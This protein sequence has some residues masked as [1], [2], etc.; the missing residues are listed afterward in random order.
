M[1]EEAV[2][3]PRVGSAPVRSSMQ[4]R[5]IKFPAERS[6][7]KLYLRD[8][9]I[10]THWCEYAEACGGVSVPSG[11]D[12]S[13][14]VSDSA[15]A[16]LAPLSALGPDDLQVI[17]IT[18]LELDEAQLR[19]I[20]H[21]TGLKGLALWETF[22]TDEAF[23]HLTPLSNLRWLDIGDTHV[24]DEGLSFLKGAA[25]LEELSLLNT[26][27]T[28]QGLRHIE[29]LRWLRRLDLMGTRV[30]DTGFDSLQS[31]T[32]LESLR[33]VDTD[34]GYPVYSKLK[35]ALPNCRIIYHEFARA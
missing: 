8:L 35:R 23:L 20:R 32:G 26:G 33:I 17:E 4:R 31:L 18:C 13:L 28:H 27:I 1:L 15:A 3:E 2:P 9:E 30:N 12:V 10:G 14:R 24:T 29:R 21:L 6:M 19:N 34:I 22:I 16:D 5:L 7:G 11:R 25:F